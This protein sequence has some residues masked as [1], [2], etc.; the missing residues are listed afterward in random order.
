MH[1]MFQGQVENHTQ[2]LVEA[3]RFEN[4]V[5]NLFLD[6]P[7]FDDYFERVKRVIMK[8]LD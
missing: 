4:E 5:I 8:R 6:L 7:N 3:V 1:R 2:S